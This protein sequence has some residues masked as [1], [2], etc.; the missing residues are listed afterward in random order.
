MSSLL[1]SCVLR[2]SKPPRKNVKQVVKGQETLSLSHRESHHSQEPNIELIVAVVAETPD[3]MFST[4]SRTV[5]NEL[6]NWFLQMYFG[7]LEQ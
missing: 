2:T 6:N 1:N 4:I 3:T 5:T 7:T